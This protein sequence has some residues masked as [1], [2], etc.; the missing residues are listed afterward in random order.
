M[1]DFPSVSAGKKSRPSAFPCAPCVKWRVPASRRSSLRAPAVLD[2]GRRRG[3]FAAGGESFFGPP[4]STGRRKM[5]DG[6]KKRT[7]CGI[8]CASAA[9]SF[10]HKNRGAYDGHEVDRI[11]RNG[12]MRPPS[13]GY[14]LKLDTADVQSVGIGIP[15]SQ[16]TEK[17]YCENSSS[18]PLRLGY[19][20]DMVKKRL[21]PCSRNWITI[22]TP[23]PVLSVFD[24]LLLPLGTAESS[25]I[26]SSL[27]TPYHPES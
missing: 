12:G 2:R 26:P 5:R 8:I 4:G 7:S 10:R 9:L 24:G 15:P 17:S 11:S 1:T 25:S 18:F 21:P 3:F 13:R 16:K 19:A 27:D 23:A 14:E 20:A 22:R 6:L